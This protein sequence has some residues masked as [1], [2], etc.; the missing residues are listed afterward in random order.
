MEINRPY[1][2]HVIFKGMD[3]RRIHKIPNLYGTIPRGGN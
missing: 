1:R 2:I 3:T